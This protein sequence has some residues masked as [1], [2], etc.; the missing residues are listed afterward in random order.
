MGPLAR[1]GTPWYT[2]T[3]TMMHFCLLPLAARTSCLLV[4][5]EATAGAVRVAADMAGE[6]VH[7]VRQAALISTRHAC[8]TDCTDPIPR[9]F[10]ECLAL[11]ISPKTQG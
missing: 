3:H 2:I 8:V 5:A 9:I 6:L 10:I 1:N 4:I 7:G 11:R